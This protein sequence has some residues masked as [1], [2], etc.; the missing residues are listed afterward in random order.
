MMK[1]SSATRNKNQTSATPALG[2]FHPELQR[3]FEQRFQSATD[4]QRRSWPHIAN[5]EHLL[6][7]APTGSGKTLT[8]FLWTINQLA[9][10]NWPSGTTQVLYVS[11]LKALNNDIQRN[12]LQPLQELKKHFTAANLAFPEIRVLTRSGDTPQADRRRMVRH[13]PEI[14]ITTP[15]SLNLILSSRSACTTLKSLKTV[16]LDEI[17]ALVDSKRGVYLMSAVERLSLQG[18]EHQ[19]IALSATV[20][21]IERVAEFIGGFEL[22]GDLN[23]PTYV[24]RPVQI[25]RSRMKKAYALTMCFPDESTETPPQESIWKPVANEC[26]RIIAKNRS[27]LIF[28][29]NRALCEKLTL[30]INSGEPELIAYA[31]HGS[32]AH[33]IRLEVE[34]RLKAGELKAIVATN[35][36]ELGI[37]IGQ[38]DEVILAQCPS[39]V[40][41]TIQR[42]GRSGHGVGQVSRG[43]L[44]TT[45]SRDFIEGITMLEAVNDRA[46]E[47]THLIEAPLDLLPQILISMIATASWTRDS[48][49]HAVRSSHSYRN[50]KQSHFDLAINMLLGKFA[51][52]R[53]PELRP[54]IGVN[55]KT[56]LLS[57]RQGT[58]QRLYLNSGVIPNRGYYHLRYAESQARIGELDEEYVW[59]AAIGQTLTL[60]TQHWRIDRITHNDVLVSPA[61]PKVPS[62]PFWRADDLNRSFHFSEKIAE[63]LEAINESLEQ[64]DFEKKLRKEKRLDPNT[65]KALTKHLKAQK[66][67]TQRDLPHRH[68]LLV[69]ITATGPGSVPGNQVILHTLWGG[70]INRPYAMALGAA[71]KRRFNQAIEIHPDNDC[72]A[73]ILPHKIEAD[74][75]LGMVSSSNVEELLRCRLE[76]SGFFAARFR[77]C[78][79]RALLISKRKF[80]ERLPLWMSRLRSQKLFD[81]VSKYPDFPI[82]LETWRTCLHDE[83]DLPNLVARLADLENGAVTWSQAHTHQPSPMSRSVAWRQINDYMYRSDTSRHQGKPSVSQSLLQEIV[84]NEAL[85]PQ[86]PGDVINEFQLKRKRLTQGY[87]PDSATE[88]SEWLKDRLIIPENEWLELM[89]GMQRDHKLSTKEALSPIADQIRRRTTSSSSPNLIVHQTILERIRDSVWR[90]ESLAIESMSPALEWILEIPV[91][92]R[93][94][95]QPLEPDPFIAEW[96]RYHG[97]VSAKTL[98]AL[99]GVSN[100]TLPLERLANE[101][102]LIAGQLQSD[103]D[104]LQYCDAENLEILLRL[105][106]RAAA[107]ELTPL[108]SEKLGLF[109]AQHHGLAATG[110]GNQ[111][112]LIERINQLVFYPTSCRLWETEILPARIRSYD[113]KQL[114]PELHEARILWGGTGKEEILFAYEDELQLGA[115][116]PS[117][118]STKVPSRNLLPDPSGKYEFKQLLKTTHLAP[119]ELSDRLWEGTW[120]GE[121]SNDRFATLRHGILNRFKVSSLSIQPNL[122][123]GRALTRPTRSTLSKWRGSQ[124]TQGNWYLVPKPK[125]P[126]EGIE[127]EEIKKDRVRVLLDR[128]GILFRELLWKESPEFSWKTLFR[129]MRLMEYSGELISGYFFTGIPG[130][131]FTTESTIRRLSGALP[132]DAIYWINASDPISLCGIS[133]PKFRKK[134]PKRVPGNHLVFRGSDLLIISERQARKMTILVEAN[135][136]S[137]PQAC[138]FLNHLLNRS[139]QPVSRLTIET[140]NQQLATKSPYLKLLR[141]QFETVAEPDRI[142]LYR[143]PVH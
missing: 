48:L 56:G 17:H 20:N 108:P 104:E 22:R 16:I 88:L 136:P 96:L 112:N 135:D 66:R 23:S 36:L 49:F 113:P 79:G 105:K 47:A 29:N 35:S 143:A 31:H 75:L 21:P 74:S 45:H 51:D 142:S 5:G 129:S 58:L 68:H 90:E 44:I 59:E 138:G 14:L 119:T 130:P 73:L 77:E 134:F 110:G 40:A 127:L 67:H 12:L 95:I 120:N 117:D 25:V 76:S 65:A 3:W 1:Q 116:A 139:F 98:A 84:S 106:R 50:L 137:L 132:E 7:T 11:P 60:G 93:S 52:S 18:G 15:E 83:F 140:I 27:T 63:Y 32:L 126:Q 28:T 128:Y 107:P 64:P 85:R 133:L 94:D 26:K 125:S 62:I 53:I 102:M 86:I 9:T 43:R 123:R 99:V 121:L 81:A 122:N 141:S 19:R 42:L 4:I 111:D 124:P 41:S 55:V 13:P 6:I 103:T 109:L 80:N 92:T 46:I 101:H 69:E 2:Q 114:D 82:T 57:L 39:S 54:L 8:A 61:S 100:I 118:P 34:Q 30:L 10:G 24:P 38:L 78:A 115:S 37:D 33:E 91:V 89:S 72:I 131:Q 70:K 71:W 97:P 87:S